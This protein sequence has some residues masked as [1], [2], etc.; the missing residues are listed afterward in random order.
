L[1]EQ[2]HQPGEIIA[3]L[4][5]QGPVVRTGDSCI[6]LTQLHRESQIDFR[7]RRDYGRLF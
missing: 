7:S 4:R 5:D 6:C 3:L 2:G 1:I